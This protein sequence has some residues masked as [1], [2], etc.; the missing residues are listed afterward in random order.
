MSTVKALRAELDALGVLYSR[1]TLESELLALRDKAIAAR[2]GAIERK[3]ETL[4]IERGTGERKTAKLGKGE[5]EASVGK[6][7]REREKQK[8]AK[9]DE[10]K[11]LW[12]DIRRGVVVGDE[13]SPQYRL[14]RYVV[15]GTY[16]QVWVGL[17]LAAVPELPTQESTD[18]GGNVDVR[19][20]YDAAEERH[21]EARVAIKLVR[22]DPLRVG[23]LEPEELAEIA[24]Q[25]HLAHPNILPIRRVVSYSAPTA[26]YLAIV[27]PLERENARETLRR[28][29]ADRKTV[30]REHDIAR[31]C[32]L[33]RDIGCGVAYMAAN[34][35]AHLDM[36]LRNVLM[37]YDGVARITDFGLV[38][39]VRGAKLGR[40]TNLL[41]TWPERAPELWCGRRDYDAKPD[42][43][44]LGCMA[45]EIAF[46]VDGGPFAG[47]S[48]ESQ[49]L[50]EIGTRLGY[51][52]SFVE[53]LEGGR[54]TDAA[55]LEKCRPVF[56]RWPDRIG[57]RRD[58][59]VL[60]LKHSLM[61]DGEERYY[62]REYYGNALYD[63]LWNYEYDL[64]RVDPR[65]RRN[66][67]SHSA[68][69]FDAYP[70]RVAPSI[71]PATITRVP[72]T[73]AYP[74]KRWPHLRALTRD[75]AQFLWNRLRAANAV[76]TTEQALWWLGVLG[77]AAKLMDDRSL[78]N[79]TVDT[80]VERKLW[81]ALDDDPWQGF[82]VDRPSEERK[83]RTL[84]A[85][86]PSSPAPYA[87][88]TKR[89]VQRESP[90]FAPKPLSTSTSGT[91]AVPTST[92][93]IRNT[94]ST[95]SVATAIRSGIQTRSMLASAGGRASGH[96]IQS[97]P[98][99]LAHSVFPLL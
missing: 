43:W 13:K 19:R 41:G 97:P 96:S 71:E 84:S 92:H 22:L 39:L 3:T 74:A 30:S 51:P 60:E 29:N 8:A 90:F 2:R 99:S 12:R 36:K 21:A 95:S 93:V 67:G 45:H 25:K 14:M 58:A 26:R 65:F 20:A 55:L 81:Q 73:D 16:G 70:C 79:V 7:S 4:D 69:L 33:L 57:D 23:G 24:A 32:R 88:A 18:D 64:L 91:T 56:A 10:K 37:G 5:P 40:A 35:F 78:G 6:V 63:A 53:L 80:T 72:D 9:E 98:R 61:P 86:A 42:E 68:A 1:F 11:R 87:G 76:P 77:L 62:Y 50:T 48:D 15:Q 31:R 89:I 27:M 17:P 47:A 94:P 59:G 66:D 54:G 28:W 83:G 49:L 46:R 82:L 34:G 52:R 44:A 85:Q 38:R 75:F